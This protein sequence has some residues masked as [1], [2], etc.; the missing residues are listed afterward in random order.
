[1]TSQNKHLRAAW[2]GFLATPVLSLLALQTKFAMVPW[3]CGASQHWSLHVVSGAFVLLTAS[4]AF[5]ALRHWRA[6]GSTRDLSGSS[7]PQWMSFMLVLGMMMSVL[8][9][10]LLLAMWLPEFLMGACD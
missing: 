7:G 5:L 8:S 6:T 9:T 3:A 2:Y 1:M 10:L 4:G